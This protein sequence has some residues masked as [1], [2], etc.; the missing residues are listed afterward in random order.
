MVSNVNLQPYNVGVIFYQFSRIR[1]LSQTSSCF[2]SDD[3]KEW[4]ELCKTVI[5]IQ[6]LKKPKTPEQMWRRVP[7][8]ICTH[9]YFEPFIMVG[10]ITRWCRLLICNARTHARTHPGLKRKRRP[11]GFSLSKTNSARKPI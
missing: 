2:L 11:F 4:S 6:P 1:L 7:F 10:V 3:Q 8:A 9:R 5:R